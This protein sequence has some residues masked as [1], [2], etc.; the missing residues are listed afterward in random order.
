MKKNM[1]IRLIISLLIPLLFLVVIQND[2]K[3]TRGTINEK[4]Q[5]SAPNYVSSTSINIDEDQD[6]IDLTFPGDGSPGN[7]YRIED[8]N[9]TL[10][11]GITVF[12]TTKNFII[13]HCLFSDSTIYINEIEPDTCTVFNNTIIQG[14]SDSYIGLQIKECSNTIVT[15]NTFVNS[16]LDVRN[17]VKSDF[18]SHKVANNTVN[19]KELG[20]FQGGFDE[21]I[22]SD[23]YGQIY[24]VDSLD[25]TVSGLN[26]DNTSISVYVAFSEYTTI[27]NCQ[28]SHNILNGIQVSYS[29]STTIVNCNCSYNKR[30]GFNIVESPDTTITNCYAN[31]NDLPGVRF[32]NSTSSTLSSSTISF[33][34]DDG[35]W[36]LADEVF[37]TN[38]IIEGNYDGIDF[39]TANL[40]IVTYNQFI[41][42]SEDGI[43]CDTSCTSASIYE[44]HFID[45]DNQAVDNGVNN[46]WFD[47]YNNRGNWWSDWVSSPYYILGTAGSI[48][49]YPLND[50]AVPEYSSSLTISLIV[51]LAVVFVVTVSIKRKK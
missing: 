50:P 39:R 1:K 37:V 28:L 33:N 17:D 34:T 14:P 26:L 32:V 27:Q 45:N 23:Q 11:A 43:S 40:C 8:L 19:G 15:N 29:D 5:I 41:E 25:M 18:T 49:P 20:W 47:I 35:V 9:F 16:G 6:F 44:N 30:R 36:I 3:L 42:N 21:I 48:D 4:E 46:V 22:S 13:Q 51:S 12:N 2:S 10:N 38:N 24:I 31:Y 7:P